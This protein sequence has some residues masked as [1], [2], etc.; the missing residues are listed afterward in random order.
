LGADPLN[1]FFI[2]NQMPGADRGV[3]RR[4]VHVFARRG[5]RRVPESAAMPAGSHSPLLAT[6]ALARRVDRAEIDFCALAST[7]GPRG[8][9]DSLDAGG[10]RA[11]Y[12]GP[13]SPFNKVLGLGLGGTAR[14]ADLDAIA[15]FYRDRGAPVQIELCP[16][17]EPGLA[18]RLS[19][20]GYVVQAFE[21]ELGC[22]LPVHTPAAPAGVRIERTTADQDDL[23]V[24]VVAQGFAVAEGETAEPAADA[25]APLA[26][27]MRQFTHP[28]LARY[29][30]LIDGEPAGGAAAWAS[31][32]ILGIF[33]TATVPRFRGRGVQVAT[34]AR[35]I[36]DAGSAVDFAIATT[37][38]GSISQ[39]NFERLGFQVL[40]TRT[41]FVLG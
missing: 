25:V 38:P 14:D 8:A 1:G 32:G 33:G 23:W 24:E 3:G 19:A 34:A 28:A 12:A 35:A 9:A 40:Y 29:L 36:A 11:L 5:R 13:G 26:G 2:I 10:G 6:A 22:A 31:G 4:P 18:L 39:R 41:I 7:C 30:A 16:L 21:N 27:V 15:A 37:A 20:R 17:A